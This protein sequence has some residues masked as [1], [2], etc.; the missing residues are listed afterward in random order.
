MLSYD[1]LW[2]P[3]WDSQARGMR[4]R[5]PYYW[6]REPYRRIWQSLSLVLPADESPL[7]PRRDGAILRTSWSK[8]P[9]GAPGAALRQTG[10]TRD[11]ETSSRTNVAA[12]DGSTHRVA[13]RALLALK[14]IEADADTLAGLTFACG[15]VRFHFVG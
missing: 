6:Q 4:H 7:R 14:D 15:E 13:L 8:S 9:G 2:P 11:R 3:R 5:L 12:N 10:I 1:P